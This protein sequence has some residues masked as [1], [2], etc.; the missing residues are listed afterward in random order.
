MS[1]THAETDPQ[2]H[3]LRVH[4]GK[5][6]CPLRGEI[7]VELCFYCPHMR[8]I[9]IDSRR[10]TVDCQT[11]PATEQEKAAYDKYTLLQMAEMLGNVSEACRQRGVTRRKYYEYKRAYDKHGFEGLR[12][13]AY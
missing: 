12:K 11:G 6:M 8:S 13:L 7:D 2:G 4:K 5:V 10:P 1:T 9:D 3:L